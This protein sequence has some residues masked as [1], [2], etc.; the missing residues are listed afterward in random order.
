MVSDY[1][2]DNICTWCTNCGNYG[3]F[4]AIKRALSNKGKNPHEVV[5]CFDI[6]CNGNGADKIDGYRFHGLHGRVLPLAAGMCLA[7]HKLPLIAI[8][9]DGGTLSEGINH[10]IHAVRNNYKMVFLL[11][12]NMNYGLTTGQP[13]AT[14]PLG[15]AMNSSPDGTQVE[16]LHVLE[17]LLPLQ[18]TFLARGFS[19]NVKQ[20]T[21]ILEAAIDHNGFAFVEI[22]QSCPTFNKAT[23]H[24]WYLQRVYDVAT[25]PQYDPRNLEMVKDAIHDL[26][27][28]IATGVLYI[29]D[30]VS[31]YLGSNPVR[32]DKSTALAEEV[33]QTDI[34]FLLN[35]FV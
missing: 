35:N 34:T 2:V 24:E 11:H 6:G 29:R 4:A 28:H 16:P 23:P 13:S 17:F 8:G 32:K 12:N 3:I 15:Q 21:G 20:L 9:G 7:N 26:Q 14:T 27:N 33:T 31:D 30:G 1:N 25:Q 19:G 22:M 18:P 10:L 5:L